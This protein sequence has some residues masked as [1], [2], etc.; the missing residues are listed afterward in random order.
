[1]KSFQN[2][3]IAKL[4]AIGAAISL[5]SGAV[6]YA[7]GE[8]ENIWVQFDSVNL[9]VN[10]Q[11]VSSSNLLYN[12]RT[13][14]PLRACAEML[15]STVEWSQTSN[16]ASITANTAGSADTAKVIRNMQSANELMQKFHNLY[17]ISNLLYTD[18]IL[19]V[20]HLN[21]VNKK[22]PINNIN[23]LYETKI[24]IFNNT[25]DYYNEQLE[26]LDTINQN[27]QIIGISFPKTSEIIDNY[28]KSIDSLKSAYTSINNYAQDKSVN[29]YYNQAIKFYNEAFD[30]SETARNISIEYL[31]I[32]SEYIKQYK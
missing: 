29:F 6:G 21:S 24:E 8:W 1:M 20:E 28:G 25:I 31:D 3:K 32:V 11:N 19:C 18:Y 5:F 14:V 16:T 23:E 9:K 7:A 17:E 10:G 27:S 15:G 26:Y 30:L 13:Y 2:T 12:D 22:I 4:A